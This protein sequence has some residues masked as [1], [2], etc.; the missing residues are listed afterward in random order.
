MRQKSI[1]VVAEEAGVAASTIRYY[2]R[3][4]LLPQP[5]REGGRRRYGSW[6][7]GQLRLI[8]S[9]KQ[10]GFTL[11]EIQTLVHG[12]P[13][14]TPPAERWRTLSRQK[15]VTLEKKIALMRNMKSV[16]ENTL[17]CQ[18]ATLEECAPQGCDGGENTRVSLCSP[19][20]VRSVDAA[21]SAHGQ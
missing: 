8:R 14:R 15:I 20:P 3:I 21:G 7:S 12:F 1:G 18:C 17:H 13:S 16:L 19:V 2:E 4:G 11:G 5:E 6:I 10:V 9:A